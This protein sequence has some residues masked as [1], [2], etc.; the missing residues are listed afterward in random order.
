MEKYYY[1]TSS[2]NLESILSTE[3]ISS[4]SLCHKRNFGYRN[5]VMLDGLNQEKYVFLFSE[6]P[7]FEI[8][9]S[10][11]DNYP[12]IVEIGGDTLNNRKIKKLSKNVFVCFQTIHITPVNAKFLFFS[13]EARILAFHNCLDSKLCKMVDYYQLQTVARPVDKEVSKM[14]ESCNVPCPVTPD[15]STTDASISED[16]RIDK[17]KGFIY[18][19]SLGLLKSIPDNVAELI[20]VQRRIYDIISSITNNGGYIN[21]DFERELKD[22]DDKYNNND[23]NWTTCKE[24]WRKE[25]EGRGFNFKDLNDFLKDSGHGEDVMRGILEKKGLSIRRTLKSVMRCGT[26]DWISYSEELQK[27]LNRILLE[28]YRDRGKN[29]SLKG[30]ID[31]N[32]DFSM[33]M[34]ENNDDE[35]DVL[36]NKILS[37][38]IWQD[39]L[40]ST[41]NLRRARLDIATEVTRRIKTIIEDSGRRWEDSKERIYFNALRKNIK[42]YTEFNV[43]DI[44]SVVYQSIAAFIL[45]GEDYTNLIDYIEQ[46]SISKYQYALAM[47]GSVVGY[48]QI[49]RGVFNSTKNR[50]VFEK[51]YKDI[52]ELLY[53]KSMSG[54]L[55]VAKN[56]LVLKNPTDDI[57]TID[58]K[59]LGDPWYARSVTWICEFLG[60]ETDKKK[61]AE[62]NK[63]VESS[64]SE[65]ELLERLSV[66]KGWKNNSKKLR[67][68]Y[69]R[70]KKE[71]VEMQ[72]SNPVKKNS[73]IEHVESHCVQTK[74][75]PHFYEDPEGW[76]FIGKMVPDKDREKLHKD[77]DFFIGDM[78]KGGEAKYYKDVDATDDKQVIGKFCDL[79]RKQHLPYF[80]DSLRE[81]IREKLLERYGCK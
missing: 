61:V 79:K 6:I 53:R 77:Y 49:P 36:F 26:P 3:S 30:I 37:N 10:E 17:I 31:V 16:N 50:T 64:S 8:H 76:D 75:F 13:D 51:I 28:V 52:Y 70:Y 41:E 66:T 19:Y 1:I 35:D 81:K 54:E 25:I 43:R 22:L 2:L 71:S 27:S 34:M 9:D 29:F 58:K 21:S 72:D 69:E 5:L 47:W 39:V 48:V 45:K 74:L 32:P 23:P 38:I 20:A 44:D 60:I 65:E 56:V 78:K 40:N 11:R 24:E 46:N 68:E 73:A 57:R 67:K 7:N 63:C 33:A 59:S 18:G 4:E 62:L 14:L 80:P 12:M 42:E 55:A 15:I